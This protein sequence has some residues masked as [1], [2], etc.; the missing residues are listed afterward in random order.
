M[1]FWPF[2]GLF[3]GKLHF[4]AAGSGFCGQKLVR[5][6]EGGFGRQGLLALSFGRT[7]DDLILRW[8]CLGNQGWNEGFFMKRI[9]L[10]ADEF[11]K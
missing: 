7:Q 5:G 6:R 2:R 8:K 10:Q 9:A 1:R 4:C 11:P 3:G